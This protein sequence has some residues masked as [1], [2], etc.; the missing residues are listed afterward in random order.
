MKNTLQQENLWLDSDK[1]VA[2]RYD[3]V[4]WVEKCNPEYTYTHEITTKIEQAII[5]EAEENSTATAQLALIKGNNL[6]W[7]VS[8]KI[9]GTT[10]V[11][12][13]T[14]I[15]TTNNNYKTILKLLEMI[16]ATALSKYYSVI[17]K[18]MKQALKPKTNDKL[19]TRHRGIVN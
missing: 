9:F 10:V 4:G 17:S 15:Q 18:V 8:K 13:T 11:R 2:S 12:E 3:D 1:I 14:V 7:C 6:I 19:I 16:P 5:K